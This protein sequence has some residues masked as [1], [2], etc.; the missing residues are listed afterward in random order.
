MSSQRHLR[1]LDCNTEHEDFMATA[2]KVAFATSD[3]LTVDQHFG[4]TEFFVVYAV[5]RER[6]ALIEVAQFGK[7]S[8]D[9]NDDKL[10]GRI[11]VLQGCIAVY[12]N[13]IGASAVNQLRTQ[14]IQPVKVHAGAE[15]QDLLESLRYELRQGPSAWL[16]RAIERVQPSKFDRFAAMAAEG[17][18]E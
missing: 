14:A 8:K 5:D 11:G 17:W 4:A 10:V 15:I 12:A 16:A 1:V 2:I 7:P 18:K 3:K 6:T 13:A 9:R